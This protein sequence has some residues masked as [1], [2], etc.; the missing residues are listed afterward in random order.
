MPR[1]A[2]WGIKLST[3]AMQEL[4]YRETSGDEVEDLAALLGFAK[5]RFP[6]R[7]CILITAGGANSPT[8]E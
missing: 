4:G 1:S 5:D 3:H 8:A 7:Q 2:S 6:V